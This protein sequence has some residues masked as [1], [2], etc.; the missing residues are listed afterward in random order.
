MKENEVP[1]PSKMAER[2]ETKF[3]EKQIQN[4]QKVLT[5]LNH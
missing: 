5:Q 2:R 3:A 1:P 4:Q